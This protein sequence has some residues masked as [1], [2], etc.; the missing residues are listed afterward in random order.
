MNKEIDQIDKRLESLRKVMLSPELPDSTPRWPDTAK[1]ITVNGWR[2]R[3]GPELDGSG[4]LV[5]SQDIDCDHI[6]GDTESDVLKEC[7]RLADEWG[8]SPII[9]SEVSLAE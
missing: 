7:Q 9:N 5:V 3:I 1:D 4:W 8:S 2:F 6:T